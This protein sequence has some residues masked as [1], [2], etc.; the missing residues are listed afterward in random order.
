MGDPFLLEEALKSLI[1]VSVAGGAGGVWARASSW[2]KDKQAQA[3]YK[4]A[5]GAAIAQ[6]SG[7]DPSR[8]GSD[9]SRLELAAPLLDQR[10]LADTRV[11]QELRKFFTND[12]PDAEALAG[13]WRDALPP[14]LTSRDLL[15]EAELFLKHLR[16]ELQKSPHFR[17]SL[18]TSSVLGIAEPLRS[19]EEE[20]GEI[21]E[22]LDGIAALLDSAFRRLAHTFSRSQPDVRRHILAYTGYIEEKTRGFVGR[23]FFL[24]EF[25]RFMA[26]ES[27]GYF[28]V[29]GDPGIGKTAL[30]A[31]MVKVRGYVH[32]FNVWTEGIRR[33]DRFLTNVCAQLISVYGLS[34]QVP[35]PE[36][37]RDAGPL[38]KV[39][40]EV[41]GRLGPARKTV[42]VV[43][44]LDEAETKRGVN[45]LYLPRNLPEGRPISSTSAPSSQKLWSEQVF[46]HTSSGT[47]KMRVALSGT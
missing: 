19:I 45:P 21:Q 35:S 41:A 39:L 9:P 40:E 3:S 14:A 18:T 31:E 33:A 44:A 20:L 22:Q 47:E 10:F 42:I 13:L 4:K 17:D 27:R 34:C 8:S 11:S 24:D 25:D 7:S 6:Y 28:F 16:S 32:H 1:A 2:R 29:R 46:V 30:A 15:V 5:L 36:E 12:E 37:G 43:D 23:Q 26:Q 38:T